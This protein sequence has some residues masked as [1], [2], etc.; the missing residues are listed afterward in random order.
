M[1]GRQDETL[2][3]VGP[4]ERPPRWEGGRPNLQEAADYDG[5]RVGDCVTVYWCD[6]ALLPA[7]VTRTVAF[8]AE[9][10]VNPVGFEQW[11]PFDMYVTHQTP[12]GQWAR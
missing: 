4:G 3:D 2:F 5:L 12:D 8:G 9:V 10:H 7:V 1:T 6:G 11:P